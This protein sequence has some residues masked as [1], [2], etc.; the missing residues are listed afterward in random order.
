MPAC[1]VRGMSWRRGAGKPSVEQSGPSEWTGSLGWPCATE[2]RP[3][4]HQAQTADICATQPFGPH[5]FQML[6]GA[7]MTLAQSWFVFACVRWKCLK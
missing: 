7:P 2:T 6:S 3:F 4:G 5:L 1:S